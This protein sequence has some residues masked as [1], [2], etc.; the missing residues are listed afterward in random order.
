M[1][2]NKK[3]KLGKNLTYSDTVG[4]NSVCEKDYVCRMYHC[5][6]DS[7][8][9]VIP[10]YLEW[11]AEAIEEHPDAKVIGPDVIKLELL[12]NKNNIRKRKTVMG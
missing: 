4:E 11:M 5:S 6:A 9:G 10:I 2:S 12:L 8:A 1:W 7:D 3:G